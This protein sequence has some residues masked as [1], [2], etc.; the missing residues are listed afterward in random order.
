MARRMYGMRR[1]GRRRASRVRRRSLK[2]A[3]SVKTRRSFSRRVNNHT[4]YRATGVIIANTDSPQG[5]LPTVIVGSTDH[6]P[7]PALITGEVSPY[8]NTMSWTSSLTFRLADTV[9]YTEL[10]A[11]YD[12]YKINWVDVEFEY[13]AD[14][15]SADHT[16]T[17]L[18]RLVLMSD[19]DDNAPETR[20]QQ[21][22]TP[23]RIYSRSLKN[24][25]T[26]RV[27][28]RVRS[29]TATSSSTGSVGAVGVFA[30]P[31]IDMLQAFI[32]HWG[33]KVMCYDWPLFND[34]TNAPMSKP[35][36]RVTLKYCMSMKNVR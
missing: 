30:N 33:L 26:Y 6:F 9:N 15:G 25:V 11:L 29:V 17:T 36:L 24:K 2:P 7:A 4:F 28:P 16:G 8:G 10:T 21:L 13:A 5:P 20:L 22:Q 31:W 3:R 35:V 12:Q 27:K 1:R 19:F 32:P 14:T 34:T 23:S 18:P